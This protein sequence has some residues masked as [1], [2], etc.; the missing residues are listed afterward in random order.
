M[1]HTQ[2]SGDKNI[3]HRCFQTISFYY[4]FFKLKISRL[5]IDNLWEGMVE[6][7]MR[8]THLSHKLSTHCS[9]YVWF[10]VMSLN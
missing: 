4:A 8:Q 1:T 3:S 2:I 9:E 7:F 6:F 10:Q 5:K